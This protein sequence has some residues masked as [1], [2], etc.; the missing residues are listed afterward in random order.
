M[1]GLLPAIIKGARAMPH[2]ACC[3]SA[4]LGRCD[5]C[6]LLVDLEGFHLVAVARG[7]CGLVRDIESY[8]RF[9]A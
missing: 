5:R 2:P 1:G 3:C 9:A 6:D 4:L 8:D 7:E